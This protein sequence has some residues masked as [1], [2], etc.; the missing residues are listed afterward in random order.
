MDALLFD[1]LCHFCFLIDLRNKPFGAVF[2]LEIQNR[3]MW[4][5]WVLEHCERFLPLMTELRALPKCDIADWVCRP[6][7]MKRFRAS[8]SGGW[9]WACNTHNC[10][11]HNAACRWCSLYAEEHT[12]LEL[13]LFEAQLEEKRNAIS[14]YNAAGYERFVRDRIQKYYAHHHFTIT[15]VLLPL[16]GWIEAGHFQCDYRQVRD[17]ETTF[18]A[19]SMGSHALLDHLCITTKDWWCIIPTAWPRNIAST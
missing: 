7:S 13:Q 11:L 12:S 1:Y 5:K 15:Q 8:H 6:N 2:P 9:C 14:S 3:I 19:I 16:L 4:M 18:T 17:N 10:E